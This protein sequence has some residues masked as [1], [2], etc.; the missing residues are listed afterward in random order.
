MQTVWCQICK[1]D[2][3]VRCYS[4]VKKTCNDLD[5]SENTPE[6]LG[7]GQ[8]RNSYYIRKSEICIRCGRQSLRRTII[9]Y[10]G[11]TTPNWGKAN[12]KYVLDNILPELKSQYEFI[13]STV[14]KSNR[15]SITAHKSYGWSSPIETEDLFVIE[16]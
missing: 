14:S 6:Q 1:S 9:F 5:T 8:N 3:E 12:F 11:N 4:Q 13:V 10:F 2:S 15:K 7:H 16:I